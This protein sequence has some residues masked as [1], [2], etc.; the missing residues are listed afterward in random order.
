MANTDFWPNNL[1]NKCIVQKSQQQ[2]IATK[3]RK[4]GK[5]LF[6]TKGIF[7]A[8]FNSYGGNLSRWI[9]FTDPCHFFLNFE[10]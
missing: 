5:L 3:V 6:D 1:A 8:K 10:G 2:N 7:D 9:F 4:S